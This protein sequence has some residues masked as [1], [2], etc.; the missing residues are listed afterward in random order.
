MRL[1]SC[2]VRR[3]TIGELPEG[4]DAL[5]KAIIEINNNNAN[6][7]EYAEDSLNRLFE[8]FDNILYFDGPE[9]DEEA[10]ELELENG[11]ISASAN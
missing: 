10:I 7:D 6:I 9:F 11:K 3:Y 8:D 2:S 4:K 5:A 1:S